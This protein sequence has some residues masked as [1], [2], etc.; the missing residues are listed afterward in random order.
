MT[1]TATERNVANARE[2]YDR[3]RFG[4]FSYGEKRRDRNRPLVQFLESVPTRANV[5]DIGC[6]AGYW[7]GVAHHLG[8]GKD[9]LFGIDMSPTNAEE[10]RAEGFNVSCGDVLS[11]NLDSGISDFTICNGVIHHTPDPLQALRELARITKPGGRIYLSVYNRWHPYFYIVHRA[12]FPIRYLYWNWNHK[13]L[14]VVYPIAKVFF[15][16]LAYLALGA[17]LDERTG[18]TM[19]MDQVMTPYAHLFTRP[20]LRR[21]AGLCGC[22]VQQFHYTKAGMLLGAILLKG[23]GE[24]R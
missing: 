6:G 8:I 17:P 16:P 9:R 4:R 22:E 18:K 12:T 15:Q 24:A 7:L 5:Y 2:M 23:K 11:L 3:Y 20:A 19:L 21:H 14:D 13:I 10:L 1:A